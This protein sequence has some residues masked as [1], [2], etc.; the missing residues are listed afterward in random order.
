MCFA[1]HLE[2]FLQDLLCLGS[3]DGA[4]DSNLFI[5]TDAEGS[6][7]VAGCRRTE[8]RGWFDVIEGDH[9]VQS[10]TPEE[11]VSKTQVGA[12]TVGTEMRCSVFDSKRC[13]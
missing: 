8:Q 12:S 13:S 10:S 9:H 4:V 7:S 3:T 5:P 6:H 1:A 2:S 11:E